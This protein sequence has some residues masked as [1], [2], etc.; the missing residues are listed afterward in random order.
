MAKSS[1]LAY[2]YV[3]VAILLFSGAAL[4]PVGKGE[5]PPPPK[6]CGEQLYPA[7]C[8]PDECDQKCKAI[9][10]GQVGVCI[11]IPRSYACWCLHQCK[12]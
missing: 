10:I 2:L 4:M 7:N 11:P 8:I 5:A 1:Y 12:H 3:F 9:N 6:P